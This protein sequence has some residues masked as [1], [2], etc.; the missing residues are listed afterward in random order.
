MRLISR[1]TYFYNFLSY[2]STPS[3]PALHKNRRKLSRNGEIKVSWH[4]FFPER[5]HK[6]SIG[7]A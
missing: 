6:K 3:G 5:I 7:V 1:H 2:F 4:R